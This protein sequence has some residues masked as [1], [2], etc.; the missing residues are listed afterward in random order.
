MHDYEF[1]INKTW[2][3]IY[4]YVDYKSLEPSMKKCVDRIFESLC[5]NLSKQ[6]FANTNGKCNVLHLHEVNMASLLEGHGNWL[7]DNNLGLL[8][9]DRYGA[10]QSIQMSLLELY[11]IKEYKLDDKKLYELK[12]N[13]REERLI[14]LYTGL[15][16]GVYCS[17][18]NETRDLVFGCNYPFRLK[19]QEMLERGFSLS[20]TGY[21]KT[22]AIR[23]LNNYINM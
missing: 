8:F 10:H 12:S 9:S 11:L 21:I 14:D 4:N 1:D 3:A 5:N 15:H 2:R 18:A 7:I 19:R 13:V 20:N 6:S 17:G 16:L 22:D 23:D